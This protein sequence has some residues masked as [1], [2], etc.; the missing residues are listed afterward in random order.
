[1]YDYVSKFDNVSVSCGVHPLYQEEA[2]DYETLLRCVSREEVVAVGETGLDYHYSAETK[3]VQKISFFDHIKASNEVNKPLII[4]TRDAQ[5]DTLEALKQHRSKQV[6]GVLHCFTESL[7]MA[8]AA[9]KMGLY[10]SISGIVTFKSAK[11]LQETVKQIPLERLLIETDSPWLAP[12]PHRG[13]ENQPAY[14][15][16]VAHFIAELKGIPIKE[17]AQATSQNF[18]DLFTTVKRSK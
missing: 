3:E 14:V 15:R 17:L 10:I 2:C 1:M 5:Q 6:S 9:L 12:V 18:Y 7:E 13:K 16:D 8:Q 4:H 11:E